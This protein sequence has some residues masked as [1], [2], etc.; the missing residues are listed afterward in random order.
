MAKLPDV[1]GADVVASGPQ[2]EE[3]VCWA[4]FPQAR[5]LPGRNCSVS[6][7]AARTCSPQR[8]VLAR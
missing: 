1:L 3:R 7:G 2:D 4:A 6:P 5:A 8:G